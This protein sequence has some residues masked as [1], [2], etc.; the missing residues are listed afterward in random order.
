M[1][2]NNREAESLVAKCKQLWGNPFKV[3]SSTHME[4][5]Q[6][7]GN[8]TEDLVSRAL[9]SYALEGDRFPPSLA[10]IMARAKS[11]KTPIVRDLPTTGF[12]DFCGG[13]YWGGP[14]LE[15]KKDHYAWCYEGNSVYV[16]TEEYRKNDYAL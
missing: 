11:L 2:I 4:W 6:M 5:A 12:C 10:E 1:S 13:P 14:S 15:D 7:A 3:T 9:D 8:L 16:L